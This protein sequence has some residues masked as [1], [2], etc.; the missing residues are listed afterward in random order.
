MINGMFLRHFTRR[1]ASGELAITRYKQPCFIHKVD[2]KHLVEELWRK[3][4]SE[5]KEEDGAT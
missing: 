5:N 2:F 1:V 3:Q 4:I